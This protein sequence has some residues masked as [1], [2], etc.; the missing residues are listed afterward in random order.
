MVCN[1]I[2]LT[3]DKDCWRE[4]VNVSLSHISMRLISTGKSYGYHLATLVAYL[5]QEVT[6]QQYRADD[7]VR[8]TYPMTKL[9]SVDRQLVEAD[10]MAITSQPR[11]QSCGEQK[12]LAS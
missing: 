12:S 1:W 10:G 4:F 9:V 8:Q 7:E 11:N 3:Q 5:S 6:N 2:D